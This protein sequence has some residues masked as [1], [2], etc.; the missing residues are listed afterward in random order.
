MRNRTTPTQ[1]MG[2][3]NVTPD[4]F[5]DG[6]QFNSV[7]AA[8]QQTKRMV[9]EGADWVDVGGESTRPGAE[10]V[11]ER[12]ELDRVVPVVEA[13]CQ[14]FD[15][16][17]SVDTSKGSVMREAVRAG[18]AMIN[19]VRALREPGALQAAAATDAMVCLMHMQG[20]PREMQHDPEYGDVVVEVKD[21]LHQQ[22]TRCERAGISK[23]R[24]LLD[25]GFGFG[26]TVR[27]NYQLLQRLHSLHEFDLPLLIGLSR[28]S[29]LGAVTQTA[30]DERMAA[31]VAGATIAALKG[32]HIVRVHDVKATVDAMQVVHATLNGEF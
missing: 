13:I 7:D 14:R 20:Q 23:S 10:A 21:F 3:L 6:G 31:S 26:K 30:V 29:M 1:V 32:A 24:L 12:E 17:V 5:S 22:I 19:D 9:D 28:K 25:P 2:I 16:H 4:S 27:H 8:I 11:T 18:A 15:V